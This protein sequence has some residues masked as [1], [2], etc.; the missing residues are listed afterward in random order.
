MKK[1]FVAVC[2]I[3]ISVF[4]G[5]NVFAA[6]VVASVSGT[7]S[8]HVG[9]RIVLNISYNADQSTQVFTASGDI[10]YDPVFLNFGDVSFD[11]SWLPVGKAPYEITEAGHIVRTAGYPAGLTGSDRFI[12]M[13]FTAKKAGATTVSLTGG[14]A[15]G[16][17]DNDFGVSPRSITINIIGDEPQPKQ[18]EITPAE[19][20]TTQQTV[21][22]KTIPKVVENKTI[23]STTTTKTTPTIEK[24]FISDK[25]EANI[26]SLNLPEGEYVLTIRPAT[27]N[28]KI[29]L[30]KRITVVNSTTSVATNTP[31]TETGEHKD[32]IFVR[33]LKFFGISW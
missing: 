4:T 28:K 32:S 12:T 29:I 18:K 6:Q 1:T 24:V 8:A 11:S 26:S 23:A 31:S 13:S 9:D 10:K 21:T 33:I 27:T 5:F 25:G 2:F 20:P 22:Q 17:D 30:E 14:M 3:F 16:Q 7:Q 15:L 19:T